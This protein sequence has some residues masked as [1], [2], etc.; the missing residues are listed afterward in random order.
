MKKI[1]SPIFFLIGLFLLVILT[2][3]VL[4]LTAVRYSNRS[5]Y[6]ASDVDKH[7]ALEKT[8]PPRL[9][10]VGGSNLAFGIDSPAIEKEIGIPVINMGLNAGLGL[11]YMLNEVKPYVHQGDIVVIVPEYQFFYI[12]RLLNGDSTLMDLLTVF[13][14][15]LKYID[16]PKQLPLFLKNYPEYIRNQVQTI[17]YTFLNKSHDPIYYRAGFNKNGDMVSHLDQPSK[18]VHVI[19]KDRFLLPQIFQVNAESLDILNRFYY[20]SRTRGAKVFLIFPDIPDV[21][22][23]QEEPRLAILFSQLKNNLKIPLLSS[24][25]ENVLPVEYFFDSLYHLNSKGRSL[26][27]KK[28]TEILSRELSIK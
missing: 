24:P 13:P 3:L 22:Y 10:L 18:E 26:R 21:Y 23:Q 11:R 5:S 20:S 1:L 14:Q 17:F 8:G 7:V 9:I 19:L 28:I 16:W 2:H 27:T 4:I 6:L 15:G 25:A 12:G